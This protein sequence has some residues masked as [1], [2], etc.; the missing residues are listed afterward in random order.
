M[1]EKIHSMSKKK[2]KTRDTLLLF[3]FPKHLISLIMSCVSSTTI[4]VLFNGSGLDPFQP[5]WGIKQGDPLSLY[6][7]ILCMEVLSAFTVE[8]CEEWDLVRASRGGIAFSHL[9][10]ADDLVLF[11]KEN[12]KNCRAVR[13]VLDT[14]CCLS[15]QKVSAE[16]SR[17]FFSPNIPPSTR[18]ELC[19]ILEFWSTPSLGK[20]LGFPI[21]HCDTQGLYK[22]K[23]SGA[24]G[25]WGGGEGSDFDPHVSP[26][27]LPP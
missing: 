15:G 10:F 19:N 2:G 4:S 3:N 5:S 8:K 21:K 12:Q 1:Q 7:F 6:L 16:K 22:K 9:F 25:G 24:A 14:F 20:Y 18:E 11:A 27:D 23:K 26:T 13:D 17:V